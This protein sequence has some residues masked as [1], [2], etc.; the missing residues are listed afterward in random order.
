MGCCSLKPKGSTNK[1]DTGT[2]HNIKLDCLKRI[3]RPVIEQQID[4]DPNQVIVEVDYPQVDNRFDLSGHHD[5]YRAKRFGPP[6]ESVP[7][8]KRLKVNREIIEDTI[9]G[10]LD[11]V[12]D[13]LNANGLTNDIV[14]IRGT[15]IQITDLSFEPE[16]VDT[17]M[18]NPL[19]FAVYFQHFELV[20]YFIGELKV[21]ICVT[22]PKPLAESEND[23]TNSVNFP[24]DKILLLLLAYEH[25]STKI[26]T[27]L[28]EKLYYF[29]P[30]MTVDQL[31]IQKFNEHVLLFERQHAKQ[32]RKG[33]KLEKPWRDVIQIVLR[34][35]T[36][37]T[38][39]F[40]MSDKKRQ[41]WLY[42][43]VRNL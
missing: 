13:K 42:D 37:H 34:S 10:R 24:E 40:S 31:L 1:D 11:A 38:Y 20:K 26:L 33:P 14:S 2:H 21:N 7:I 25:K 8:P 39:Y 35:K 22:A 6:D 28:L 12:I 27:Y 43:F 36:A 41:K 23:P 19:H 4:L 15:S 16:P 5:P 30:S 17:L 18:W 9:K 32:F 29:W 3:T